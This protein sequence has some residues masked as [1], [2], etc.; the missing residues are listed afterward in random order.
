MTKN[1][2]NPSSPT[3]LTKDYPNKDT[4]YYKIVEHFMSGNSLNRFEAE[5]LGD[6]CLNSTVFSL[7]KDYGLEIP[8][9]SER[10][11]NSF[12][13]TSKVTRYYFSG[14]D[15]LIMSSIK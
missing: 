4:K 3:R 2:K 9:H 1:N 12:G 7:C 10:V 8:R 13:G 14:L 15:V 11:P 6:H 5:K